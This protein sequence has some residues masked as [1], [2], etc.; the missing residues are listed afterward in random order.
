[1]QLFTAPEQPFLAC[2]SGA[3][4]PGWTVMRTQSPAF[5]GQ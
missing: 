4:A 5:T 3:V 2:S 1:M